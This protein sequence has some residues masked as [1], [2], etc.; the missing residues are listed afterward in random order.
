[1]RSSSNSNNIVLN[2]SVLSVLCS[3]LCSLSMLRS[4]VAE[5]QSLKPRTKAGNEGPQAY[6]MSSSEG[7][8]ND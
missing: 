2:M 7:G 5:A 8:N 1:M 3:S 4:A 6:P